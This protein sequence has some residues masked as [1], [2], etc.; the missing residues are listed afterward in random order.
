M[1]KIRESTVTF[2][3]ELA[4]SKSIPKALLQTGNNLINNEIIK[5]LSLLGG[6]E[7]TLTNKEI[8]YITKVIRSLEN[9]ETLLKGTTRKLLVKKQNSLN[10]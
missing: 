7:I 1:D 9:R 3:A 6:S 10:H 5:P 4:K 8:K 2:S